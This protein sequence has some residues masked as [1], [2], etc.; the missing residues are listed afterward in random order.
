MPAPGKSRE[1]LLQNEDDHMKRLW[2]AIPRW[3]RRVLRA[4]ACLLLSFT[5]L[6]ASCWWYLHPAVQRTDGVIYGNRNG[7]P[8]TLDVIQPKNPNGLAVAL[9]V[10]GGWKSAEPGETPTWLVAPVLRRGFT[11]FAICHVSQPKASVPEIIADMHRGIRFVRHHASKY[12]IDPN[13]IGVSGGSA[14][15]HLSLMLA[16]CGSQGDHTSSD[17]VDHESS[18]VQ[19]V[20]IF[21]PPTDLIDMG[22]STENPGALGGPPKSYRESFGPDGVRHWDTIGKACSPIY[23]I[24]SGLPPT[25]I[26]HGDADTLVPLDQSQRYQKRAR[27]LGNQVE[28]IVHPDGGHG[29]LTMISDTVHFAR[30]FEQHLR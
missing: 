10:S 11:V 22:E 18:A 4:L 16:T 15:G 14:G 27:A 29:W 21:Y 28:I 3:L 24:G 13:R 5:L 19:A 26:Y 25:L 6:A 1:R 20:A 8:L 30:W 23:Q 12:G 17:P 9:M 2:F 7:T